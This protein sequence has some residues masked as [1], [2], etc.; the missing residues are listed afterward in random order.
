MSDF[1]VEQATVGSPNGGRMTPHVTAF[2]IGLGVGGVYALVA[3]GYNLVFSSSAVFNLAQG[4]LVTIG[5]LLTATFV[6]SLHW[7]ALLTFLPVVAAV[8]LVALVQHRLTIAPLSSRP[9]S[10]TGGWFITTLGA[11]V[12]IENAAQ[13]IW[14]GNP[15]A[16]PTLAPIQTVR[17]GQSPIRIEYLLTFGA[18]VLCTAVLWYCQRHTRIGKL[19]LATAEDSELARRLGI[20]TSRVAVGAF[21]IAAAISALAG[22]ITVPVTSAIWNAGAGL[23]LYAFVAVTMGGLGSPLGPLVGGLLL[24]VIQEEAALSLQADYR[25]FLSLCILLLVLL[26]KPMGLFGQ[27]VERVV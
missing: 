13:L 12:I 22:Y 23:S 6:V 8:V 14:G 25:S 15:R 10:A 20:D 11:S 3:I 5:G 27:R 1:N 2:F 17:I 7:P 18:A 16:V 24:G 4:D 26:V 21:L 9:H 19:W